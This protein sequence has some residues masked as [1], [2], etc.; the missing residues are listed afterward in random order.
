[1]YSPLVPGTARVLTLSKTRVFRPT[2]GMS[3]DR[4]V[5]SKAAAIGK[6]QWIWVPEEP[7][8]PD[9]ALVP[10]VMQGA[11]VGCKQFAGRSRI[12]DNLEIRRWRVDARLKVD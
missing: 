6:C 9:N 8:V 4:G 3:D 5:V 11:E 2:S 12:G 1:F 10:S 7:I